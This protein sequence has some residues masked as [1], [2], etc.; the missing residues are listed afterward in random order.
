M[1]KQYIVAVS[2]L[3]TLSWP[4]K[5]PLA[6][7]VAV[8]AHPSLKDTLNEEQVRRI[9]MGKISQLPNGIHATP[10]IVQQSDEMHA[11]FART[12]LNRSTKQ[13]RSYWAKR[14][15]TGKSK[16]P[17]AVQSLREMK[18]LVSSNEGY[19]GYLLLS[20]TDASVKTVFVAPNS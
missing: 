16:P 11:R 9:Y 12:V 18:A 7:T 6:D 20:D 1:K 13:L 8:I 14:L 4:S 19:I 2:L 10:V 15:F 5:A 17:L 3:I